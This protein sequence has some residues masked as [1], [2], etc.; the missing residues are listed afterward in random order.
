MSVEHIVI[1]APLQKGGPN[2]DAYLVSGGD[3][4]AELDDKLSFFAAVVDG[5]G[6]VRD[7]NDACVKD[8]RVAKFAQMVASALHDHHRAINDPTRFAEV[9]DF[10]AADVDPE[11]KPMLYQCDAN[12]RVLVSVGAVATCLAVDDRIIHVAHTGDCRLYVAK[13]SGATGH[14]L[15]T[16]DHNGWNQSEKKRIAP[17]L[18]STF[19]LLENRR[20]H[21]PWGPPRLYYRKYGFPY[22]GLEPTRSF[23][24]W[25]YHPVVIHTPEL[26]QIDTTKH[27]PLTVYALCSDG[28]NAIVERI[29]LNMRSERKQIPL[30]E[31]ARRARWMIERSGQSI[32]VTDDVTIVFFRMTK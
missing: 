17:L 5:H 23:G 8:E 19:V 32:R 15:L 12:N 1:T 3:S 29:F 31:L 14:D 9:F 11:F 10:T 25:V 16:P 7:A 4:R 13:S 22:G 18:G 26:Q 27:D 21:P 2:E 30:D 24:D 20:Q 28:A 6:I